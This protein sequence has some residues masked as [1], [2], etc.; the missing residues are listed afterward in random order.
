SESVAQASAAASAA[1]KLLFSG[2]Y[3]IE[4]ATAVLDSE[5][6]ISCGL[7]VEACPFNAISLK[8]KRIEKV[9]CKG[10]GACAAICPTGAIKQLHFTDKQMA[11]QIKNIL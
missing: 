11:A 5:K 7:C 3:R 8:E 1:L 2:K 4:A 9:L 6:C 10:C